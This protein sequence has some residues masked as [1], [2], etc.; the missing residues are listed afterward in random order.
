VTQHIS[1]DLETLGI[2]HDALILSIGAVKFDPFTA[3][4]GVPDSEP[5]VS[6][7]YRV[8]DLDGPGG[9]I[10]AS[11]VA[12]WMKQSDAARNA[13]FG[14]DVERVPLPQALAEFSEWI[15]FTDELEEGKYPDVTLW[16][17]GSK[18]AQWLESAYKGIGFK[19]PFKYWQVQDQRT[20]TYLLP[21][22]LPEVTERLADAARTS[23]AHH[24]LHDATYQA[25][26]LTKV[27]QALLQADLIAA[28]EP[29][30]AEVVDSLGVIDVPLVDEAEEAVRQRVLRYASDLDL[31]VVSDALTMYCTGLTQEERRQVLDA[32]EGYTGSELVEDFLDKNLTTP[33]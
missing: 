22:A 26:V 4:L 3:T 21:I 23:T 20:A 12:W 25:V 28:P 6:T 11:T 33:E 16:A 17:R 1:F 10:D 24:A 14:A 18:D 7:F 9:V 15:G 30:E 8:I 5:G 32:F 29:V 2:A 19:P 31:V 27:Y 13:I